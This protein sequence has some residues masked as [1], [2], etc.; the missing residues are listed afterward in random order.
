[1][2]LH[3][4]ALQD[5]AVAFM[6]LI[7]LEKSIRNAITSADARAEEIVEQWKKD[8][9]DKKAYSKIYRH[10][11]PVHL[12]ALLAWLKK[13]EPENY[14][15]IGESIYERFF[16]ISFYRKCHC[17]TRV[18]VSEWSNGSLQGR[19]QQRIGNFIRN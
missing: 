15:K 11:S 4:L 10:S 6:R 2:K 16:G 14:A 7:V 1:M 5:K 17:R 13:Y 12:N 3:V 19:I 9:T 8:G 18:S